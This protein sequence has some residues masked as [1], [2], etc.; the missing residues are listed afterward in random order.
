[1]MSLQG[2]PVKNSSI[3]ARTI[4]NNGSKLT[5]V[6]SFFANK[7]NFSYEEASYTISRVGGAESTFN[8]GSK[9]RIY[10]IPLQEINGD[11]VVIKAFAVDSILR[12]K[13]GCEKLKLNP[14]SYQGGAP[15]SQQ[16]SSQKTSGYINRKP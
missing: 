6:S 9:G 2:V 10:N 5:L 12:G 1:M 4:F 8:S 11:T 16:T 3:K 15:G 13:I 7:N 14:S